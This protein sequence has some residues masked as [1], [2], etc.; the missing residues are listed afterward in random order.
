MHQPK[1]TSFLLVWYC[2]LHSS[3]SSFG[4]NGTD[5]KINETDGEI[6]GTDGKINGTDGEINGTNENRE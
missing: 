5:G 4:Q 2:V 6:S 3:A 1:C